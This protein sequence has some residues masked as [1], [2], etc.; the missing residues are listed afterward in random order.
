MSFF[1]LDPERL[2]ALSQNARDNEPTIAIGGQVPEAPDTSRWAVIAG[3]MAQL[4]GDGGPVALAYLDHMRA[5]RAPHA[6]FTSRIGN[7]ALGELTKAE[8]G[9][10]KKN[11]TSQLQGLGAARTP[12]PSRLQIPDDAPSPRTRL[13]PIGLDETI[14]APL[15]NRSTMEFVEASDSEATQPITVRRLIPRHRQPTQ[16][17][18]APAPAEAPTEIIQNPAEEPT[19]PLGGITS[20]APPVP[21]SGQNAITFKFDPNQ[22]DKTMVIHLP[23]EGNTTAV[24]RQ[25]PDS[26]S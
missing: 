17:A 16:P 19:Q 13:T 6:L 22:P 18:V 7:A 2:A 5:G 1:D 25:H 23:D 14:T 24:I 15:L 4:R 11:A 21:S 12:R 20:T 9:H 26:R 3:Y 8:V 10:M